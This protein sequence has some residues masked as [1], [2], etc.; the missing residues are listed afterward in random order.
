MDVSRYFNFEKT[1]AGIPPFADPYA[2]E[3]KRIS[4]PID[5]RI[6]YDLFCC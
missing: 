1:Q 5:A 3:I 6:T 4:G 2:L